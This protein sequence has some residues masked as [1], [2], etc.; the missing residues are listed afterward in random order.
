M[1]RFPWRGIRIFL[2]LCI[3]LPAIQAIAL[4]K[5][6]TMVRLVELKG[7]CHSEI[8]LKWGAAFKGEMDKVAQI[9]LGVIAQFF[10]MDKDA[11]V[12]LGRKYLPAARQFDPEFMEVLKGFAKGADMEFNTLF[13]IRSRY[14]RSCSSPAGPRACAPPLS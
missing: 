6:K 14:W 12:A 8:G 2:I 7:S 5:G 13:A 11:V 9:E 3:I 4:G 10:G 1:N